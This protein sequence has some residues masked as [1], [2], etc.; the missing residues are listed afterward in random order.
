MILHKFWNKNFDL[1]V[2]RW[3]KN[4]YNQALFQWVVIQACDSVSPGINAEWQLLC[5]Y[6]DIFSPVITDDFFLFFQI[7]RR[8]S[9]VIFYQ[10]VWKVLFTHSFIFWTA[11][12]FYLVVFETLCYSFS[13]QWKILTCSDVIRTD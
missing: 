4:G 6:V 7:I 2:W 5:T 3:C 9:R 10:Q 8:C 13:I 11:H 12:A 1:A